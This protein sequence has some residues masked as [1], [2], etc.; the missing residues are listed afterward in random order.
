[1]KNVHKKPIEMQSDI[2]LKDFEIWKRKFKDYLVLTG[3]N[4]AP[5]ETQIATLRGFLS[6]DMY[7]KLRISVGVEDDTNLD[8][9]QILE[10]LRKFIRSKRNIALDRVLF[11]QRKQLEGEDFETF[12]VAIRQIAENAD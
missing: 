5:R 11:D 1:M 2:S 7:D 9:E 3:L 4:D 12:L 6:S 8:V 10:L